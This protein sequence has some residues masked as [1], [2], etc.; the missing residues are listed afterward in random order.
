MLMLAIIVLISALIGLLAA[1]SRYGWTSNLPM[2]LSRHKAI[3]TMSIVM[4]MSMTGVGVSLLIVPGPY[5]NSPTFEA[6]IT[7]TGGPTAWGV[8]M[9]MSGVWLAGA[10][11]FRDLLGLTVTSITACA[12]WTIWALT[13]SYS[14]ALGSGV[15]GS[16]VAFVALACFNALASII[17]AKEY[18]DHLDQLRAHE[19]ERK[20]RQAKEQNSANL[21]F[22]RRDREQVEAD[23]D[24]DASSEGL[25]DS[26][27]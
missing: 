6:A 25:G 23:I 27:G 7:A 14:A 16:A 17:Y 5:L 12:A 19:R 10:L 24:D 13:I 1:S 15:P 26:R 21:P 2:F 18:V 3:E 11:I 9:A 22:T 8:I 20:A 4:S